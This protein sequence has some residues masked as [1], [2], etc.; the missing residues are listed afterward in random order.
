MSGLVVKL[1]APTVDET[2]RALGTDVRLIVTGRGAHT[3]V[4]HVREAILDYHAR[5]SRFLP[6]SE[7]SALNRDP[8]PVV[9]A[10]AL[11]RAAVRAGLWAAE[12]SGGLVDPCLL[13]ALEAAGYRSSYRSDEVVRLPSGPLREAMPDPQRRWREVVVDDE[14]GTIERPPACAST[15][16]ARGRAMRL[17]SPRTCSSRSGGGSWTAAATSESAVAVRSRSPTRWATSQPHA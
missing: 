6:E 9:P 7:L 2:F 8:R 14:A 13:D 5:L 4:A 10:S 15:S 11:L 12:R 1:E 17:T 16:A 3:A